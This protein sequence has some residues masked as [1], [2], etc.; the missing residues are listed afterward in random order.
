[1]KIL[2]ITP[3]LKEDYLATSV[4]EGLKKTHHEIY[5]TDKGNGVDKTINDNE[6]IKHSKDCDYIFAI[7]GKSKF[8]NI[9]EPK[10]YLIDK[11]NG[12]NKTVYIDGSEYNYTGFRGKTKELLNPIFKQKAKY[13]FKRECLPEHVNEGII[14]LP[15]AAL[16]SYFNTNFFK[17]EIDIL[18]SYGQIETGLRKESLDVCHEF[19]KLNF[20]VKTNFTKNYTDAI[21]KSFI[22]ID[23]FGAGECNAR[24]WQIMSNNS[25]LFAQKYNIIIPNLKEGIHYVSWISKQDLKD[26]IFYYL[27]NKVELEKIINQ[28]YKNI[29]VNHTSE[30]RVKYIFDLIKK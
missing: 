3:I 12:W 23:A 20:T 11:V 9:Q 1:M 15:F 2:V 10:F 5:Y 4:I 8:N 21:R 28:S 18:C 27:N 7:W 29:L 14:P 17:K 6:F 30:K 19:E 26:K 16:D 24:M 13:Y 22:T 25:C